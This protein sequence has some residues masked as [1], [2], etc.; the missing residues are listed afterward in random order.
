M[1]SK[2]KNK[3]KALLGV[4]FIASI[5]ALAGVGYA[6]HTGYQGSV[7]TPVTQAYDVDYVVVKFS[8]NSAFVAD[9]TFYLTWNTETALNTAGTDQETTY[10]WQASDVL[11]HGLVIEA[12]DATGTGADD[13][14]L[15]VT[16][17][18]FTGTGYK[19]YYKVSDT[20]VTDPLDS[21]TISTWTE[22]NSSAAIFTDGVDVTPGAIGSGSIVKYIAWAAAPNPLDPT[23]TQPSTT[24][25]ISGIGYVVEATQA[26]V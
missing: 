22:F 14:K 26:T 8:D 20:A 10:T 4:A 2:M 21:T 16:T 18:T 5:I 7:S 24:V 11:C 1:K 17:P 19:L 6:V 9:S 15:K 13:Y 23:T 25:T 3:K 12:T